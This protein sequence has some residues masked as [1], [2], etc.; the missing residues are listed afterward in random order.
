MSTTTLPNRTAQNIAVLAGAFL[1]CFTVAASGAFFPPDEWFRTLVR[2]SFAPPNW[3]FGPV[4]TLLYSMMA[5][6]AWLVWRASGFAKARTALAVFAVQ[7]VLNATWSGLFF[8]L[9][10]MGLAFAEI[11]LLWIAIATTIAAFRTHSKLAAY[12]LLPYLAW[13]SFASVLNYG[14]WS[15]N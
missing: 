5:I 13:V 7:L 6:S 9:H 12:M 11:I 15:L 2:P 4:W 10:N 1:L 3:L 14:F 8:G